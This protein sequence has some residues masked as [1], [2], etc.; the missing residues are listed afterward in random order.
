VRP[1]AWFITIHT[2]K[3]MQQMGVTRK[4]VMDCLHPHFRETDY[5]SPPRYGVNARVST[6]GR[7]AV[8]YKPDTREVVTVLWNRK[9]GR[10]EDPRDTVRPR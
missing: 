6:R 3:R 8:V 10:H 4:E 7:L 5:P 9:E 1:P 2:M